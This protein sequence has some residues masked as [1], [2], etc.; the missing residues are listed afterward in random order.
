MKKIGTTLDGGL[1]IEIQ[2]VEAEDI[3]R[4]LNLLNQIVVDV[5]GQMESVS[6]PDHSTQVTAPAGLLAMAA[7]PRL[8]RCPDCKMLKALREF[9]M[10][11]GGVVSK[12]CSVCTAARPGSSPV[13]KAFGDKSTPA[14]GA[15]KVPAGKLFQC[16][17][18][19]KFKPADA[20]KVKSNGQRTKCCIACLEHVA[21]SKAAPKQKP[22]DALRAANAA[23]TAAAIRKKGQ[24]R[25]KLDEDKPKPPAVEGQ[26]N[27]R[28][29]KCPICTRAFYDETK[30]LSKT[31]CGGSVCHG[32][33]RERPIEGAGRPVIDGRV[34]PVGMN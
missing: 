7:E 27:N 23:A 9:H 19:D 14:T 15:A 5:G 1:I 28:N 31:H 29:K 13:A 17:Y 22:G 4:A 30:G 34:M 18:C 8:K 24:P 20:F 25:L 32:D 2:R 6:A 11:E 12:R 16:G 26:A 33:T 21:A 10:S 3:A